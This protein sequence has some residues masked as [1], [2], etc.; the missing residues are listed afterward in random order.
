M[1][2]GVVEEVVRRFAT[3]DILWLQDMEPW[4]QE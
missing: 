2:Y 4:S 1:E 3:V